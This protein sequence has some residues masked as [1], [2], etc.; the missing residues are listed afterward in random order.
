[1]LKCLCACVLNLFF[2]FVF[3][4]KLTLTT[5]IITFIVYTFRAFQCNQVGD[6]PKLVIL[7]T[8]LSPLET[9]LSLLPKLTS[10]LTSLLDTPILLFYRNSD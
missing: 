1:M 10:L 5:V 3:I 2:L 4:H 7:P 8:D 9:D 6:F